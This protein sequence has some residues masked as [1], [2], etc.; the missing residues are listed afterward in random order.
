MWSLETLNYLNQKAAKKSRSGQRE[1]YVPSL[2]SFDSF[3]PFPLP[4]LGSY[5]P[6]GWERVE[7]ATWFADSSGWG[8][9]GEPALAVSELKN[10]LRLYSA[11]NPTHGFA[12]VECGQFQC[13]V[14]AYRPIAEADE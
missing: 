12:L 9:S 14:G 1:P 10:E 2:H 4:H 7:E 11:E 8:R 6:A 3:P 5:V 13:Y